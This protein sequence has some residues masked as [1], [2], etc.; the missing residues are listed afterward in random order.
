[1]QRNIFLTVALVATWVGAAVVVPQ[2][3]LADDYD[4][5]SEVRKAIGELKVGPHDW[6]QW[7]GSHLRNN[8]T[9]E[10]DIPTMW[11]VGTGENVRWS[12]P[13]G[14]ETYGNPVVAN[15]KVYVGTNN[16]AGYLKPTPAK[17]TW[18]FCSVLTKKPG[19]S[20]GSIRA[21][22]SLRGE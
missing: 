14:S 6:P 15:G 17:L 12:M 21:K 13:L 3:A 2:A 16:G 11:D 7:A 1:M 22:S 19:S 5:V 9:D 4:A 8:V 18:A 10:A 20:C